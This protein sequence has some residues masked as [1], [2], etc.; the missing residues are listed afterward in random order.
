MFSERIRE[1]TTLVADDGYIYRFNAG[2]NR[3]KE[4]GPDTT[5]EPIFTKVTIGPIS[6]STDIP[7]KL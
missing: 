3:R 4:Q 7:D 2:K 5:K 1:T 6:S